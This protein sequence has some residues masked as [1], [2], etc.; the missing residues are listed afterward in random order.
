MPHPMATATRKQREIQQREK[1]ILE[2]ARRMMLEKGYIGLSMDRIATEIEYSKGTIYQH[3][4]CKEDLVA[5]LAVQTMA[6][7]RTM[8]EAAAT[9]TGRSRERMTG[10]GVADQL[11]SQIEPDHA[12]VEQ[13]LK[14]VSI[15][16]KASAERR[17]AALSYETSCMSVVAGIVR[18]AVAAGDLDLKSASIEQLVFGLWSLAWGARS[19][20]AASLAIDKFGISEPEAALTANYQVLLD[21]YQWHPLSTEWDYV[22]TAERIRDELIQQRA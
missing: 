18:D 20:M 10:I 9:R 17:N 11:F 5:A 19:I 2:T 22:A 8:F 21:G 13:L 3:F 14:E 4:T 15:W 1:L 7:R 16:D 12:R 6:V